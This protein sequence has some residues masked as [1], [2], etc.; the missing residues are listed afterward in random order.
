MCKTPKNSA[1]ILHM[2]HTYGT[3]PSD[4]DTFIQRGIRMIG[5]RTLHRNNLCETIFPENI[6]F[7]ETIL[8]MHTY[9]GII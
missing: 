5:W 7:C 1:H 4:G 6:S 9:C 8:I 2:Y 3:F